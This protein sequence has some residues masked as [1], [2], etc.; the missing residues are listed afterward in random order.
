MSRLL[1]ILALAFASQA[2]RAQSTFKAGWNTYNTGMV[3]HEFTYQLAYADSPRLSLVDS[4]HILVSAD[5]LVTLAVNVPGNN[6]AVYYK[7]LHFLN[8]KKQLLK[9]E[10]Y[11]GENLV[12][13]NQWTYDDKNRKSMHME[14][15]KLNGNI[16]KKLY[17]YTTDKKSGDFVITESA[18][19]NGRVEFYTKSYYD[20]KLVK[21]K[22]V[23]LNDNNKD[24]VHIETYTYGDNGKVKER[25]VFFPEWKVTKK[26]QES[27]GT[28]PV[29][30]YKVAPAGIADRPDLNAK[31]A[32]IKKVLSKN[33]RLLFDAECNEFEYKFICGTN[34]EMIVTTTKVN[35]MKQVV[36]RYKEK[37]PA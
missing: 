3:I 5:S 23:R 12:E 37:L 15:N 10:E 11:K 21:Y 20:K 1:I 36:F 29:K 25:S 33:Q 24:V 6:K 26:F 16:F 4:S 35:K 7:T 28:I 2:S 13:L 34:C 30:C 19:F 8:T 32:Y 31:A 27:G 14:D 22:E 17:D 9:K 18:Y